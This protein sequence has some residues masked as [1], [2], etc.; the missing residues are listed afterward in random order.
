MKRL[1]PAL[2]LI[3]VLLLSGC[4]GGVTGGAVVCNEPY[5]LV[6]TD[7]C[8]DQ[9][10]NQICDKDETE[11][12][13]AEPVD[14]PKEEIIEEPAP[15]PQE[16]IKEPEEP[17]EEPATVQNEFFMKV[18]DSVK[19]D[20][21]TITLVNLENIPRLKAVFDVDGGER[22]VFGTKNVELI[23]GLKIM[24]SKYFNLENAI[25]AKFEKLELGVNEYLLNPREDVTMQGK[26]VHLED[27]QE[28]GAIIL[29]I[30][31]G[32]IES[33]TLRIPEGRTEPFEG[34]E[35]TNI[36]GFPQGFKLDE[37]AIVKIEI[38]K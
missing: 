7:C 4:K 27:V 9:N 18:G 19:F 29:R 12:L 20:K 11:N 21:K 34:L 33:A 23:K 22:E 36:D 16:V 13:N 10:D 15:E 8:L 37:Y 35:I 38:E 26:T 1:I 28:S 3:V 31:G 32:D 14:A 2:L 24:I 25:I 5:I 30:S 17:Q 6:G